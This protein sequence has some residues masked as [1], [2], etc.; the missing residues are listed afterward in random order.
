VHDRDTPEEVFISIKINE[1]AVLII[2]NTFCGTYE[3]MSPEVVQR[4]N[5]SENVDTW[6]LGILIFELIDGE[7]PFNARTNEEIMHRI[8]NKTIS[9]LFLKGFSQNF[10]KDLK[11][12]ISHILD[13]APEHRFSIIQMQNSKWFQTHEKESL[14]NQLRAATLNDKEN[15]RASNSMQKTVQISKDTLQ[16]KM[17]LTSK[18]S[19][20]KGLKLGF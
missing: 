14:E 7:T 8:K 2:R 19:D 1:T 13:K 3:Y 11:E 9:R 20:R 5:Y 17:L 6:S 18:L 4:T 12:L 16:R 10:N 15:I